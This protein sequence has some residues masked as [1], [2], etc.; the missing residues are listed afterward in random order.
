MTITIRRRVILV[1]VI[2]P[3]VAFAACQ[4][5]KPQASTPSASAPAAP[6]YKTTASIKEIMQHIVDPAG[7]LIWNSVATTVDAKGIHTTTPKTDED[8]MTVRNGAI[9]L[10]EASNL[11]MMPGRHVAR[12]GEK[13]ETPGIELEPSE[14]EALIDKDRAAW[15]QRAGHLH[16]IAVKTLAV[17]DARNDKALFDVGAQIDEACENC[18]RQYWYPNEPVQPLTNEPDPKPAK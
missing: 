5:S 16:D 17:I 7:D 15:Y 1:F 11:L 6:P 2:L 13:S 8:W 4:A 12:P 10:V 14:M 18:H 9:M 3:A